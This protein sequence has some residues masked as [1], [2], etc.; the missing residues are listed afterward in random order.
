MSKKIDF[1]VLPNGFLI[2]VK[3]YDFYGNPEYSLSI[4]NQD[5][6]ESLE[7]VFTEIRPALNHW[8]FNDGTMVLPDGLVIEVLLRNDQ[9]RKAHV[10]T[11]GVKT[12]EVLETLVWHTDFSYDPVSKA[13]D[14]IAI[15]I[16][17]VTEE[18]GEQLGMEV[19][20]V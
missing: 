7:N 15:K 5:Y 10:Y 14:I 1:S 11:R 3:R 9:K 19:I 4:M 6:R 8:H 20:R 16:L 13:V 12:V 2:E 18:H 17:G